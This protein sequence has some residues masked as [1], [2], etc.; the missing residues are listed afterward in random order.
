MRRLRRPASGQPPA[1]KGCPRGGVA[2]KPSSAT[3]ARMRCRSSVS[4]RER[5]RCRNARR[6]TARV[7]VGA[8]AAH[9][10]HLSGVLRAHVL[11]NHNHENG[12]TMCH[13]SV[14]EEM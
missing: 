9:A 11:L 8:R 5:R 12:R 4:M 2:G 7:Y 6:G 13:V 3:R 1:R 14:V 10:Y